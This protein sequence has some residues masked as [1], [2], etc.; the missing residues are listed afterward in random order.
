MTIRQLL[1]VVLL[2]GLATPAFGAAEFW[3]RLLRRAT[4]VADDAPVKATEDTLESLHKSRALR[5][6][7]D[8]DLVRQ[9]RKAGTAAARAQAVSEILRDGLRA[10]PALFRQLDGLADASKETVAL[11]VLGGKHLRSGVPDLALRAAL[12]KNGGADLVAA[13]GALGPN[14]VREALVLE[15]ALSMGK[16]AAQAG[17]AVPTLGHF[18]TL[19]S[20]TGQVGLTF[21]QAVVKPHWGKL[22]AGG[23]VAAY[24]IDPESIMDATGALTERGGRMFADITGAATAGAVKGAV[25]GAGQA[26]EKVADSLTRS[27]S[28][29]ANAIGTMITCLLAGGILLAIPRTRRWIRAPVAWIRARRI[30]QAPAPAPS[31]EQTKP[32]ED[33]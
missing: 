6:A 10:D 31:A 11:M 13:A 33:R 17:G 27:V 1:T 2:L 14:V 21:W 19:M 25:E 15:S 9:G 23:F 12:L 24:L 18:G 20:R 16:V 7:L 32:M 4:Q 29:W 26:V 3:G 30:Q 8:D 22:L 28:S 5:K